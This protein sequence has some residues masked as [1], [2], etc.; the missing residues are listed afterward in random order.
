MKDL[1]VKS[2]RGA[3]ASGERNGQSNDEAISLSQ[4]TEGN[5]RDRHVGRL[6]DHNH[7]MKLL[8]MTGLLTFNNTDQ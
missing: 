8:A 3:L 6:H 4:T 7:T 1:N 5:Q 2:L